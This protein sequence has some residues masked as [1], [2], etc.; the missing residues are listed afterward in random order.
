MSAGSTNA[1][2]V[3]SNED[4]KKSCGEGCRLPRASSQQAHLTVLLTFSFSITLVTA[5]FA[6]SVTCGTGTRAGI[7]EPQPSR[8][9][10]L[11]VCSPPFLARE[12][13]AQRHHAAPCTS[14]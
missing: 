3:G 4:R 1:A 9:T 8:E 6:V 7:E 10:Q 12:E 2:G 5:F 11:C 14:R 13:H